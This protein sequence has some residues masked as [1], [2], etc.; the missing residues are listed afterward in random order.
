ML[1][2]LDDENSAFYEDRSAC[3][4]GNRGIDV[5]PV[6]ESEEKPVILVL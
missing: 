6:S 4:A 5:T 3:V 2:E 1:E